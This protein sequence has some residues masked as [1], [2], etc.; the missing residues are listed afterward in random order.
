MSSTFSSPAV[1]LFPAEAV[2]ACLRDAVAAAAADQAAIR[3]SAG[4]SG[5]GK[6]ATWEPEADSL[7]VLTALTALEEQFGITLPDDVVPPG[8]YADTEACIR[9]LLQHARAAWGE[10]HVGAVT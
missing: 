3:V 6:A 4:T 8:G 5:S 9:H 2:E 7:V 1:M 10:K